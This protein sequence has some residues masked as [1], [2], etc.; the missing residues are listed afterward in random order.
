M[1]LCMDRANRRECSTQSSAGCKQHKELLVMANPSLFSASNTW[2][3]QLSLWRS[4]AHMADAK[5]R[6][7]AASLA[8]WLILEGQNLASMAWTT[9]RVS[10]TNKLCPGTLQT[11]AAPLRN[12][13][14]GGVKNTWPGRCPSKTN[15]AAEKRTQMT[16]KEY[17]AE[18]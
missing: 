12:F 2:T 6:R 15:F 11:H 18:V 4:L 16:E 3:L 13:C 9:S 17:E 5:I 7:T 10:Q 14:T 1:S 8:N